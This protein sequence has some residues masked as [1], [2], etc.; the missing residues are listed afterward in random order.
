[1]SRLIVFVL[2]VGL[3]AACGQPGS[4]AQPTA[5]S[6]VPT[7]PMPTMLASTQPAPTGTPSGQFYSA[8]LRCQ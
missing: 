5:T 3:L 4:T 7:Q 2:I 1:M 6:S 8:K